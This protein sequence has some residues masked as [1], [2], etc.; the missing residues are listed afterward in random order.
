MNEKKAVD[1]RLEINPPS[2]APPIVITSAPA[3]IHQDPAKLHK[4]LDLLEMPKGTEVRIIT[5][6]SSSIV[7]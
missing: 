2:G 4:L 6:A 1:V 3:N 7:R 5:T